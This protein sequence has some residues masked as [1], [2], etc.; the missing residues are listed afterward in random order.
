MRKFASNQQYVVIENYYTNF[1]LYLICS[2]F[3][4]YQ[5]FHIDCKRRQMILQRFSQ[6]H[7]VIKLR[8]SISIFFHIADGRCHDG[9]VLS[10]VLKYLN[11]TTQWLRLIYFPNRLTETYTFHLLFKFRS[12]NLNAFHLTNMTTSSCVIL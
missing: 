1:L 12:I 2:D 6:I 7:T 8:Y 5:T 10:L 9:N 3:L 11:K 4:S